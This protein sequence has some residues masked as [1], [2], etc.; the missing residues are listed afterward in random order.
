[1]IP[2]WPTLVLLEKEKSLI[3]IYLTS[4]PLDKYKIEMQTLA[5]RDVSFQDLN[6]NMEPYKGKELTFIGM[7]TE[8]REAIGK[9]GKPFSF[10]VLTDYT[11]SYKMFFFTKDYVEYGKYCKPGLYL[12]VKGVVQNRYGGEQLEF[13]VSRIELMDD[14]REKYFKSITL[15]VPLT[16]LND[17][18]I[19]DLER[20]TGKSTGKSLLK[21][22]VWDPET[23]QVVN[24]FS[25]N[26][27]IE[28]TNEL[29]AYFEK[30]EDLAFK[31][32]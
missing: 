24:L 11:D 1:V 26:T 22:D 2:E 10:L 29:L 13:K 6:T 3:G 31:I 12:M 8:A 19:A 32:N 4:H 27:R 28:I 15:K 14:I 30:N 25:R 5:S 23:K 20:L 9:S 17:E 16:A 18:M 7:V 21:F